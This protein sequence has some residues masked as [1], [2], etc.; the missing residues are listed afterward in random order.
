M[1]EDVLPMI[2]CL[3]DDDV[4]LQLEMPALFNFLDRR[5]VIWASNGKQ[6]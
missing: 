5:W 2:V 3:S 4:G 1:I 6:A